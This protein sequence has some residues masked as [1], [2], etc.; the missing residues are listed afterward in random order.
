VKIYL[1]TIVTCVML[2]MMPAVQ[3]AP[4]RISG[5]VSIKYEADA[6]EGAA[7]EAGL[8]YTLT[9]KG[10]KEIGKGL[11]LYGRLGVQYAGNSSL[12]DYDPD[13]YGQDT[14]TVAGIDQFGM[15]FR[16]GK[17][18]YKLG[19][20][21][22]GVGVTTLLYNRPETNIGAGAFVDG[23]SV[24]G[25]IG[26]FDMNAIVARENNIGS[27]NNSLYAVRAGYN[28][29]KQTSA[30]ATLAQYQ[31][32]GAETSRHLA[33]DGTVAL[34]K[35]SLTAEY[36]QSS[37]RAKNKAHAIIWNYKFNDR[38]A[39]Y[40]TNFRVEAN[41]DMGRQS[42]YDNNNRGFHYGFTHAFDDKL[43]L[44][45]VYK[46]QV[47]LADNTKNPKVEITLKNSF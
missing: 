23:L 1:S 6:F 19:R 24:S 28:L 35:H 4:V 5:D 18:Q 14:K 15:I 40:V 33:V 37:C 11:S 41:G 13:R 26:A 36:T 38:T 7:T 29:S 10:E 12:G 30:G 43:S 20:Q 9:L 27:S 32:F 2:A 45:V 22:I 25:S 46:D 42:E 21:D 31:T 8:R 47:A 17:L 39:L 44:E 34:G 3:A 16:S